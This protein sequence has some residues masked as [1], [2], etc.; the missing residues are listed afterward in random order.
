MLEIVYLLHADYGTE[1]DA[2]SFFSN[3]GALIKG[4]KTEVRF[5]CLAKGF[6]VDGISDL[7]NGFNVVHVPNVGRDIYSYILFSKTAKSDYLIF[8]NTSSE[9]HSGDFL[10]SAFDLLRRE[11]CGAVAATGSLGSIMNSKYFSTLARLNWPQS[12]VSEVPKSFI[13]RVFEWG[14]PALGY[15]SVPHLRTNA[16]GISKTKL[17]ALSKRLKK[18]PIS[19]FDSLCFESGMTGMSG[20]LRKAG[21]TLHVVDKFGGDYKED[22]WLSSKTYCSY[23]QDCLAVSDNRTE[24][25]R[26]ADIIM[27]RKLFIGAWCN[28]EYFKSKIKNLGHIDKH[29]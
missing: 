22:G 9:L 16:F 12:I 17:D 4:L 8:F 1:S 11:N 28:S 26:K 27:K 19:R 20:L 10:S 29:L 3:V 23:S 25:Y 13:A 14:I 21:Q 7:K 18:L 15:R 24:E 2:I 5:T 6:P